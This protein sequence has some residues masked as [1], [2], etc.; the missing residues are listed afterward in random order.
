MHCACPTKVEYYSS[1]SR[2][3]RLLHAW[4][5]MSYATGT[6]TCGRAWMIS[7]KCSF[8]QRVCGYA[9]T[10]GCGGW[11]WCLVDWPGYAARHAGP[12][13]HA[14]LLQ[15]LRMVLEGACRHPMK[16]CVIFAGELPLAISCGN[17]LAG[18]C[19]ES[20]ALTVCEACGRLHPTAWGVFCTLP[21]RFWRWRFG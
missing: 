21:P 20:T 2:C 13:M 15:K 18:T 9:T 1:V 4:S 16:Q 19:L 12:A 17:T 11:L 3:F 6:S 10:N 7:T 14:Q 8:S 5:G